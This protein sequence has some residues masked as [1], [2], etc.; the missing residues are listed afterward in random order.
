MRQLICHSGGTASGSREACSTTRM[1]SGARN[2]ESPLTVSSAAPPPLV[3]GGV[4]KDDIEDLPP[5]QQ[6]SDSPPQLEVQHGHAALGRAR[7][8]P[9]DGLGSGANRFHKDRIGAS[10]QGLEPDAARPREEVEEAHSLQGAARGPS[11]S[12]DAEQGRENPARG[13]A[14]LLQ[15]SAA[16]PLGL[17]RRARSS[18]ARRTAGVRKAL[19]VP[20]S[21]ISV[22]PS[23]SETLR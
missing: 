22:P 20:S 21:W 10:F 12:Q 6:P 11:A 9:L 2:S 16:S 5:F 14:N 23:R 13:G 18:A 8:G 15:E 3:V 7:H 1:P 4:G 19:A 17:K